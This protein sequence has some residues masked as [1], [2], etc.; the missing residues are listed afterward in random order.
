MLTTTQIISECLFCHLD[1]V[2][3]VSNASYIC[4]G[5]PLTLCNLGILCESDVQFALGYG[6][7]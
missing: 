1:S 6:S 3:I 4:T 2:S 7:V 5:E